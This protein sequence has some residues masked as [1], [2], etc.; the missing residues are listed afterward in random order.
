M[1]G[2]GIQHVPIQLYPRT[3]KLHFYDI[4]SCLD[5][6]W[7]FYKP[8]PI[9]AVNFTNSPMSGILVMIAIA[10]RKGAISS[11]WAAGVALPIMYA[12]AGTM[13]GAIINGRG[14]D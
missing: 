11:Q 9:I 4:L 12:Q 2:F 1:T 5:L 14:R 3:T 13:F 10:V 8:K 6:L 7:V